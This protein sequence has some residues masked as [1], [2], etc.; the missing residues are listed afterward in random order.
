MAIGLKNSWARVSKIFGEALSIGDVVCL[1][2]SD[3][4][5]YKA[6]ANDEALRSACGIV[7]KAAAQDAVGQITTIGAFNGFSN[8]AEGGAVYLSETPGG[9][10]QVAPAWAQQIGRAISASEIYFVFGADGA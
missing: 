10:T 6:D 9:V 8:L 1:K 3:G 2:D 7:S 4:K 5:A